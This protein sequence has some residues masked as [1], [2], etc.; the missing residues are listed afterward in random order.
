MKKKLVGFLLLTVIVS[1]ATAQIDN[2]DVKTDI[3]WERDLIRIRVEN[4]LNPE[5]FVIQEAKRQAGQ[6]VGKAFPRILLMALEPIV[7]NSKA[8]VKDLVLNDL[9]YLNVI[10]SLSQDAFLE[11]SYLSEDLTALINE[12]SVNLYSDFT[13]IF[14]THDTPIPIRPYLGYIAAEDY[15][16]VVIVATGLLPVFGK[17][18]AA[19]LQPALFPK[20]LSASGETLLSQ[21]NINPDVLTER[22]YVTYYPADAELTEHEIGTRPLRILAAAVFGELH[23][24]LVIRDDDAKKLLGRSANIELLKTGKIHI[25]CNRENLNL[26]LSAPLEK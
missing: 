4:H 24:D 22:G 13:K 23:T 6:E 26:T 12:Y 15:S 1:A 16:A 9:T 10:E 3:R 11:N 19:A 20:L 2:F 5:I 14:V 21:E 17:S 7:V 25:L 8:T 18:E